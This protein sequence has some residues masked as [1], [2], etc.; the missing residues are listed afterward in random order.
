MIRPWFK[1][2]PSIFLSVI[3][4]RPASD[5]ML[6]SSTTN[7]GGKELASIVLNLSH[8]MNPQV[9]YTE[10]KYINTEHIFY[11]FVALNSLL[12]HC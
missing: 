8:I 2:H 6:I 9:L 11:H 7:G 12:Q 1:S 4:S 3:V 5:F 10:K